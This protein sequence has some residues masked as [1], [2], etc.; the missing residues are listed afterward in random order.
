M[1]GHTIVIFPSVLLGHCGTKYGISYP[2]LSK[3][4]F[5]YHRNVMPILVRAVLGVFWFSIQ[6]WI[7]GEAL[8]TLINILIPSWDF[9]AFSFIIFIGINF[10]IAFTGNTVV[11]KMANYIAP[12]L[13]LLGTI[14][15]LWGYSISGSFS[16]LFSYVNSSNNKTFLISFLPAL[17]AMI[18]FDSTIAINFSDYTRNVK[19]QKQQIVGQFIG[20]PFITAFIVFV[21]ICGTAASVKVFGIPIWNPA[22]L[23]A[24]FD[25]PLIVA[26]FS[27]FIILATL[28]TN[29]VANLIPPGIIISNLLSKI[30]SYKKAIILVCILAVFIQPWKILADP[31][32]FIFTFLGGFATFLGPMTGLYIAGYWFQYKTEI[33]LVE[34][35]KNEK[36]AYFYYNGMNINAI[37]ILILITVFL[38]ACKYIVNLRI[39][40]DNSYLIGLFSSM[41]LYLFSL[42]VKKVLSRR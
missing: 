36:S 19:K 3:L 39:L 29:I 37:S 13:I 9:S 15:I 32:N 5:G 1:V 7:G 8:N 28:T 41:L 24:R 12:I 38:F 21:G 22:Q 25:N 2:M 17:P 14:V 27:I 42:K 4:I 11:K 26:V 40:Y 33:N 30:F 6:A 10:Y 20:A 23:V 16:E 34:L 18:A 31:E 35:Y